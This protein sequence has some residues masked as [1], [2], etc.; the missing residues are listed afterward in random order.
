MVDMMALQVKPYDAGAPLLQAQKIQQQE[1][2]TQ[3]AQFKQQQT[4]LGS[5]ARGLAPFVNSPD[6]PQRWAETADQLRQKGVLDEAG[7]NRIKNTP[8]P[9][10]LKSI[11]SQTDDP[12]LAFR[13][14]ESVREQGNTD[15]SFGLQ[16]TQADRTYGLAVRAANRADDP[17]PDGYEANPLAKTDPTQPKYRPLSGG[18]ND[19][20][21]VQTLAAAKAKI[22]RIVAPG[23]AV[24]DMGTGTETYKNAGSTDAGI[25]DDTADMLAGRILAGEK[26]I[27]TG[28]G[29][30]AQGAANLAKIDAAVARKMK[31]QGLTPA[32]VTQRGIDLVGDTSRERTAATQ[33]ARMSAAGIEAQGAIKLGREA[34][35]LVPRTGWVPVNK[36]I[37]AYQ[38][39]TSDPNL[40]RFGAANLTIIN[41]YAR[42]INPNGVG[43]VADKEHASEMLRTADGPEAY[44]A[45]LEQL[46]K[47]IEMAHKSPIAA[48]QGFKAERRSRM[49]GGA[50]PAA[51]APDLSAIEAELRRRGAL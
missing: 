38:S 14:E 15:R 43:T 13:R 21:T 20:S 9:L 51:S 42:A 30:G 12:A 32:D 2:E 47:E 6:F 5:A 8:S 3:Q 16:K 41:T 46:D 1:I 11:I 4:E 17:T 48:R 18:P 49:E 31:D 26:G 37:Q 50:A 29:R 45:V 10:M 23:E 28:Y 34:S 7:Y 22:P 19:P 24:V 40:K 25:P 35:E 36:A 27:K 44:K 33:E 39:N